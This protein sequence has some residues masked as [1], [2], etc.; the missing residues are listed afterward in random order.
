MD[1]SDNQ[2]RRRRRLALI[3]PLLA[4]V[5]LGA[6]QM[7]LALFT[8]SETVDAAFGTGSVDLDAARID[9][10]VLTS[11]AM[12]PGDSITDDVVVENDGTAELRYAMT[13]ATT[14][15]D[16]QALRDVLTLTVR[17]VDTTTPGTPCDD[18]NGSVVLAAT[19]LG[20]AAAGFGDPTAGADTGDRT[21]AAGSSETLCFRVSLPSG[22]GNAYEGASATTTFSFDAEQTANNP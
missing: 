7:S 10:L 13:T 20:A 2:P 18:F 22:T 8:D 15:P 6:G 4:M 16:G 11:T 19:P 21:L 1:H 17:Q 9:A 12:M 14:N 5:T 3:L